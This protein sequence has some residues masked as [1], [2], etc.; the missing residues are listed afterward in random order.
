MCI[1]M[2]EEYLSYVA[3]YVGRLEPFMKQLAQTDWWTLEERTVVP[4]YS[5]NKN[6]VIFV[7][8]VNRSGAPPVDSLELP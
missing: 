2:R 5:F 7:Y 6:G 1:V 8:R 3:E 4:K